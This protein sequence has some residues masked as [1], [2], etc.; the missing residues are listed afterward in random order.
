MANIKNSAKKIL[1]SLICSILYPIAKRRM[2]Y[3]IMNS[4]DTLNYILDYKMSVSRYGDGE[5]YIINDKY[6]D[7]QQNDELL[8]KRL[9]EVLSVPIP[10]HLVCLPYSF[11]DLRKYRKSSRQIWRDFVSINFRLVNKTTPKYRI[12]GDSLFTRFYMI[13]EDKSD[14]FNQVSKLKEIWKGKKVCIIEGYYTKLGVGNDLLKECKNVKRILCPPTNAFARYDDIL[15]CVEKNISKDYLILCALGMTATVLAYDLCKLDYQAID[16]GHIDIE[17]E[18]AK[19][20]VLEK[21][22][23]FGKSV[24][25]LNQNI[26][27]E[28]RETLIVDNLDIYRI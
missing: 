20:G 13:M 24:N 6:S 2:D 27:E 28:G 17:Y 16:I 8:K 12:Y 5:Y 9:T 25:E 11:I 22:S 4:S 19:L 1:K 7:F 14:A 18:W 15:K 3:N 10:N 26:P 23:V 21:C